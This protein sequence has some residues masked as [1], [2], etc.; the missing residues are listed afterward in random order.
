MG[1][2]LISGFLWKCLINKTYHISKTSNAIEIQLEPVIKHDKINTMT[3]I[4]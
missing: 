3:S 4:N 2:F 1:A